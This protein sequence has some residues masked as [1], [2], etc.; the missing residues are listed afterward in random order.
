MVKQS[1]YRIDYCISLHILCDFFRTEI[2]EHFFTV[3]L[4]AF[5]FDMAFVMVGQMTD[6]WRTFMLLQLYFFHITI[7][8]N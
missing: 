3:W 2:R 8:W 1:F 6:L 5:L 4:L 7:C